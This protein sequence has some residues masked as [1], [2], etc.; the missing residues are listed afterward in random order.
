[1]G[2]SR[3]LFVRSTHLVGWWKVIWIILP[4]FSI[5]TSELEKD[6]VTSLMCLSSPVACENDPIS[7]WRAMWVRGY[8]E[9]EEGAAGQWPQ[10]AWIC[11]ECITA[12]Q[13]G[14]RQ[15]V[16]GII[17]CLS[18][19]EWETDEV[20]TA[21]AKKLSRAHAFQATF[22]KSSCHVVSCSLTMY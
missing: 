17:K 13:R 14:Y 4:I 21:C 22:S 2:D 16:R 10:K 6:A 5:C 20:C 19:C 8:S 15:E 7:W 11:L 12:T 3:L 9:H 1:M 18:S